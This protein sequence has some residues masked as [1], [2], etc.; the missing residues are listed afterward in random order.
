MMREAYLHH[1]T[2]GKFEVEY[3]SVGDDPFLRDR[4]G[5][6]DEALQKRRVF[7]SELFLGRFAQGY[8]VERRI[9]S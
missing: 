6:D 2:W 1:V 9:K 4:F 7:I 5:D 3:L 8:D